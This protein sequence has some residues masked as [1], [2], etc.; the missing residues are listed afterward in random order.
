MYQNVSALAETLARTGL[1]A[2][3]N[4]ALRMAESIT[5][6][7]KKVARHFDEQKEIIDEQLIKKQNPKSYRDEIEELIQKTSP[8]NKDY[9]IMVSGYQRDGIAKVNEYNEPIKAHVAQ[10]VRIN[11]E[12]NSEPAEKVPITQVAENK[13]TITNSQEIRTELDEYEELYGQRQE[14]SIRAHEEVYTNKPASSSPLPQPVKLNIKE[15]NPVNVPV[16]DNLI[17]REAINMAKNTSMDNMADLLADDRPLTEV[18][19]DDPKPTGAEE[20]S[21]PTCL[22]SLNPVAEGAEQVEESPEYT[23]FNMDDSSDSEIEQAEIEPV[24]DLQEIDSADDISNLSVEKEDD[25]ILPMNHEESVSQE[26]IR[27]PDQVSS[28]PETAVEEEPFVKEIPVTEEEKKVFKNP[29][30]EVDLA[31]YFKFG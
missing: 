22:T 2:S 19:G 13:A 3:A 4:E 21:K 8:E 9:H 29:I 20:F 16:S 27:T 26:P 12:E 18:L 6:T 15:E 7:E 5:G 31:S 24:S 11:Y 28:V 17:V 1:A 10:E 30:E 25:F 14:A 23:Y